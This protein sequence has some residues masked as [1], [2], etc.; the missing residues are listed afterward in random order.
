MKATNLHH[1]SSEPAPKEWREIPE[2]KA[3]YPK[4]RNCEISLQKLRN[5]NICYW[6]IGYGGTWKP[7]SEFFHVKK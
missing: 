4:V 6:M 5:L 2:I 1:I 3:Q 7:A